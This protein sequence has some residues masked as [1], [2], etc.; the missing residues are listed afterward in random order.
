MKRIL[1]LALVFCSLVLSQASPIIGPWV[2]IF[3]GIDHAVG[4]N[5]PEANFPY[6]QVVHAI[7]IDLSDPDIRLL[8][9]P[10]ITN[11]AVN[12]RETGGLTVKDFLVT[13]GLQL[14]IN[15][16][17]FN[18][19]D[20]Y[21]P[22]GTPMDVSGLLISQGQVVSAQEGASDSSS[23]LFTTNNQ[24]TF[25]FTN[26]PPHSTTGIFNA[27]SGLYAVL[28]NGVNV[29]SNYINNSNFPHDANPRT[30]L[31]AS[32]N[33]RYFYLLTIDGRQSG[34]SDGALDWETG[35]WLLLVGASDGV[36]MDGGGS[37]TLIMQDSTGN[38]VELNM[39]SAVADSGNERTVGAHLGF[40]AKPLPGFI[41]DVVA[42]PDDTAASIT[43]TTIEPSTTKVQYDLT[44]NFNNSS[45]LQAAMVTNHAVLLTGLTPNTGYYFRAV[46][47]VGANQFVSPSEFFVTTN[48][49]TTNQL[50]DLTNAWKYTTANLD[51]VNWT[52]PS[53]DDSAWRGPGPALLWVDVRSTGPNPAVDPKN[54][55]MPS[56]PNNNGFPYTTYY[57]RTHFTATNSALGTGL[58]FSGYIDDGAVF[59]LNGTEIYRLRIDPSPTPISNNTLA[60]GFPCSGDATCLDE[61]PISGDS[62][63]NLVTGDNVLAVEVHNY[64]QTSPDITF[65]TALIETQPYTSEPQLSIAHTQGTITLSWSRGGFTLQRADVPMASW[66][67]V[68]GP[69]ISSPFTSTNLAGAQYFRLVKP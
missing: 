57:F 62:M 34:Y 16:N 22:A 20:Y 3:K 65:G 5:T 35:A 31:G 13:N 37:T 46:S 44:T 17:N 38:P 66:T 41:N 47:S 23:I 67:D 52:P 4:T 45:T 69:I 43:W 25:I 2:P 19:Q 11:Y 26:W 39:S 55:Q 7:R 14:A 64:N 48:Y 28:V 27:V 8:A 61:F 68:P 40:F 1:Q 53:Y 63:T 60:S 54:T 59:Y 10:R 15:A 58:V 12:S 24:P 33:R 32:Q 42:L 29:G 21:L 18:P 9:T 6:L 51:G 56:D 30:A 49:V 50:F 36:N